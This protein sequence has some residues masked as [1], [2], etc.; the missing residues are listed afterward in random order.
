MSALGAQGGRGNI[1]Y[2]FKGL[3]LESP[4]LYC[5]IPWEKMSPVFFRLSGSR[6][7]CSPLPDA[8]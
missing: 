8:L 5:L 7:C 6:H 4:F 2:V 3:K 1:I